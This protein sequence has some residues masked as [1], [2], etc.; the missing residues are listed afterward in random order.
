MIN[1]KLIVK[2]RK[3]TS[4]GFDK[5]YKALKQFNNSYDEAFKFLQKEA[6]AS[7]KM[8]NKETDTNFGSVYSAFNSNKAVIIKLSALTD[9]VSNMD[10]FQDLL[11]EIV[12]IAINTSCV[13]INS[14][15]ANKCNNGNSIEENLNLISNKT[16]EPISIIQY[17]YILNE[18][19]G[20]L[21]AYNHS[22]HLLS[23]IVLLSN[24]KNSVLAH[25]IAMQ[26]CASLPMYITK[27]DIPEKEKL[28][29]FENIKNSLDENILK[30]P[31]NIIKNIISGKVNKITCAKT[32]V[33]QVFVKDSSKKVNDLLKE[34]NSK[35]GGF[36]IIKVSH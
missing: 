12:N 30:K 5:C 6:I 11:K 7:N 29:L 28:E 34:D 13:D 35:I 10:M 19:N 21:E 20:I 9:F 18:E 15:I 36:R 27:D 31:E 23:A 32:L 1:K 4:F 16:K 3:E 24:S 22:N 25:D 33:E 2:L 8:I 26:I 14:L 17:E